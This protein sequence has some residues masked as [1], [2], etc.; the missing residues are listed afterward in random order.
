MGWPPDSQLGWPPDSLAFSGPCPISCCQSGTFF[1]PSGHRLISCG[2]VV[3]YTTWRFIFSTHPPYFGA[4][5]LWDKRVWSYRLYEF[6]LI[7]HT[8]LVSQGTT[9]ATSVGLLIIQGWYFLG[10]MIIQVWPYKIIQESYTPWGFGTQEPLDQAVE[11]A[12][13]FVL[14]KQVMSHDYTSLFL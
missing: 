5:F 3:S 11:W 6:G 8:S 2:Q 4:V 14:D 9:D 10:I 13:Y 12:R 1:P 7:E